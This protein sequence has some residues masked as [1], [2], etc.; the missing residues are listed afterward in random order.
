MC[1]LSS[2]DVCGSFV[3]VNAIQLC[4]VV[5]NATDTMRHAA[6][7]GIYRSEYP[8]DVERE[9]PHSESPNCALPK[10]AGA[11]RAWQ[12]ACAA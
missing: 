8:F 10:T 5:P 9:A 2:V 3:G 11:G 12:E 1:P 7:D 4:P 6:S